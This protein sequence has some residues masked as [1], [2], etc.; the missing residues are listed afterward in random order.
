M[1]SGVRIKMKSPRL[2][3]IVGMM[4]AS[5]SAANAFEQ[6]QMGASGIPSSASQSERTANNKPQS[7]I[8]GV[9]LAAPEQNSSES[10]GLEVRLPGFGVIGTLPKF[11]F[12]LELLYGNDRDKNNAE[13]PSQL[14]SLGDEPLVIHGSLK[15]K[16]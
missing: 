16:F 6:T 8:P 3:I 4:C 9:S 5:V 13:N 11:D 14:P 15:H 7:V 2:L 1:L 10:K 12:G